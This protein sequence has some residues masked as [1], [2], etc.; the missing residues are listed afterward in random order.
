MNKYQAIQA[1][2]E[3]FGWAAYNENTVPDNALEINNNRYI[4]YE[5][6]T[7]SIGNYLRLSAALWH[8]STSWTTVHAKAEEI[9][10]YIEN[11]MPPSLPIDNGRMVV[12]KG[13]P[14]AQDVGDEDITIRHTVLLIDVE[15]LINS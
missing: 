4:T 14:F 5:T 8:R 9:A 11:I 6:A 1:F 13:T 15:F 3:S 12:R 2:W 7:D 10:N